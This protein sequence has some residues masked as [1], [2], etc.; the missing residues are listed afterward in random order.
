MYEFSEQYI[1]SM[2]LFDFTIISLIPFMLGIAVAPF[3]S[4]GS[5]LQYYPFRVGSAILPLNTCLLFACLLERTF[6]DNKRQLL[7]LGSI[8]ILSFLMTKPSINFKNQLLSLRQFPTILQGV[9]PEEKSLSAWI[10][11]NTSRDEIVI[12]P[13][14]SFDSFTWLT[15]RPTIAKFKLFPQ[16]KQGIFE[17]YERMRNLSGNNPSILP[18][19]SK[20]LQI[21]AKGF[22]LQKVLDSG[23]YSLTTAQV[24]SLMAKYQTDYFVTNVKHK[25]DLSVIYRNPQYLIYHK[26]E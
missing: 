1:A 3:D 21:E 6:V 18:V 17:W 13:P 14:G 19:I 15:E 11:D 22:E 2:R 7:L 8:L 9:S 12:S 25:L 24:N 20:E 23:Y 4:N 26:A 5:F 10:R 16:N